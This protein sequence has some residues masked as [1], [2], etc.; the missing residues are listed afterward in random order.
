MNSP[1][2]GASSSGVPVCILLSVYNGATYL[3]A[4]LQSLAR[5]THTDWILLW[6]DDGSRD[7]GR[8][9]LHRFAGLLAPG[10]C[11]EI[12]QGKKRLGVAQSFGLLLEHVPEGCAVAFCDQDD[13]WFPDKLERGF[14]ALATRCNGQ[15]PALYCSRQTLTDADLQP[16]GVSPMLPHDPTFPMALTQNIATGCTVLLSPAAVTLVRAAMPPPPDTLHDW[17]SY[18][19]VSAAGGVVVADNRP[20]LYYRQHQS[21]AVGAPTHWF[22]RALAAFRRGPSLFMRAFR[23]NVMRLL[24]QQQVLQEQNRTC[25]LALQKALATPG[26]V[27]WVARYRLL[28]QMRQLRRATFAEQQIFCLWFILG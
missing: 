28:R 23:G 10:R 4:L 8:A 3:E 9:I 22:R 17:W 6:R 15:V 2:N 24:A 12:T 11:R 25:L 21:N 13:V 20:S 7:D 27:G 19:L 18:L 1:E 5:Q 26:M 16:I 14:A